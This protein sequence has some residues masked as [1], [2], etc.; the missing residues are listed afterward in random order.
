MEKRKFNYEV[1]ESFHE[2]PLL[3]LLSHYE[4]PIMGILEGRFSWEEDR[5]STKA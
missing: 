4:E 3:N 1:R 2:E 5:K